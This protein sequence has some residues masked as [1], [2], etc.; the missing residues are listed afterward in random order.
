MTLYILLPAYNEGE[1]L[2]PLLK[3]IKT[4]VEN[5]GIQYKVVVYNDGST[6]NT[7]EILKENRY[8]LSLKII[9]EKQNRGLGFAF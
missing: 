9:G 4:M 3:R 7:L 8:Q 2:V 6:D 1:S 5:L